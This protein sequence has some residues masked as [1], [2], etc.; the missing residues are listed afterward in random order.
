[1]NTVEY[2]DPSRQT[3]VLLH[4][5]G[6]SWWNY[7][8]EALLLQERFHVVLPILDG[9]AGS[10]C[11]FVSI[12]R[13]AEELLEYLDA[14][15]GGRV[16]LLGGLSLGAQVAAEVLARRADVCRYAVL[17]SA[18]VQP[19]RWMAPLIGP[20]LDCSYWLI[21]RPWFARA[22]F[23][24]LGIQEGL[25]ADYFRDSSRIQKKDM[26]AFLRANAAYPLKEGLQRSSVQAAVFVGSKEQKRMQAS[27]QKLH[28]ALR[29][30]TLTVL[31][32]YGHGELS[33]NRPQEY[34]ERLYQLMER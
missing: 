5:G 17:E 28:G 15:Y 20:T 4:G 11:G 21:A 10:D 29:H 32:G 12:E 34:V 9:H 22:Q 30:S 3:L 33:L 26:A 14:R 8:A 7:R 16:L 1:M 18:L 13:N 2:G 31:D 27:A 6:L 19:M 24:A 25:F 23:R